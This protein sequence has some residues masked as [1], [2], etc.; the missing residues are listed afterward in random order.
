MRRTVVFLTKC[1][2]KI[3][4]V[5][6]HFDKY[7]VDLITIPDK[8][9]ETQKIL[10]LFPNCNIIA[11][12]SEKST[13]VTPGTNFPSR[14][15]H[16]EPAVHLSVLNV[17]FIKN[18]QVE[19]TREYSWRTLGYIDLYSDSKPS[20]FGWDNIFFLKSCDKN[21]R[22]LA[23]DN[24]KIS[25]RDICITL[26]IKDRL[27]YTK[28]IDLAFNPQ[29]Y[30]RSVDFANI[31]T[32][33]ELVCSKI[34]EIPKMT[35]YGIT[36]MLSY[37][38]E[39]GVYFSSPINRRIKLSWIPGILPIPFTRKDRDPMH[40]FTYFIHDCGHYAIRPDLIFTGN[41]NRLNYLCYIIMRM[42]SEAITIVIADMVF[43]EAIIK[44]GKTYATLAD[45]K[46]SPLFQELNIILDTGDDD[47]FLANLYKLLQA[48]VF[49][50]LM[51]NDC[52]YTALLKK[53][54]FGHVSTTA[55]MAL[56]EYKKKY[57]QFFIQDYR[58]TE[59]N[60]LQMVNQSDIQKE[61]Y[62][63][64][65]QINLKY[66]LNL[67]SVDA[68]VAKM[69][70]T[71]ADADRKPAELIQLAFDYVFENNVKKFFSQKNVDTIKANDTTRAFARYMCNQ[72]YIFKKLS[73]YDKSKICEQKIMN[74]LM[75]DNLVKITVED[76]KNIRGYYQQY[77]E[78]CQENNFITMDDLST[79]DEV[80]PT[81]EPFI[82][83]Y[84]T[85]YPETLFTVAD[86]ILSRTNF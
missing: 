21:Y 83:D 41:H 56:E 67:L 72:I 81:V 29:S 20:N 43:T 44:S 55:C 70:F 7:G 51:G 8:K 6:Q 32:M 58:W 23:S 57:S 18:N 49:Y 45:R 50:C 12:I 2:H 39:N 78:T 59:N 82:V 38:F 80:Y 65:Q 10:Q 16:L 28:K 9:S 52:Y 74:Y 54:E 37:V 3:P 35:D 86:K 64:V 48:N 73:F 60:Y 22:Q 40:E 66:G 27:Y 4:E 42:M 53:N 68:F 36:K 34:Q 79:Y 62:R 17:V 31:D 61:W 25:S 13:L 1:I 33:R 24:I 84:D 69:E 26:F 30:T 5:K 77:L 11:I 15:H 76:I 19:K 63:N 85:E 46:I 75:Q 14:L 47:I 71:P